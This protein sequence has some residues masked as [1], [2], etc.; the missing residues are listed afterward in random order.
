MPLKCA[1]NILRYHSDIADTR[2]STK[3]YLNMN[4]L[5]KLELGKKMA[6]AWDYTKATAKQNVRKII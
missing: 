5:R 3:R 2:W 4:L 1:K 6:V